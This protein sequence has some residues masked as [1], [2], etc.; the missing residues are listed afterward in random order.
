MSKAE[1]REPR[2]EFDIPRK[3]KILLRTDNQFLNRVIPKDRARE[4]ERKKIAVNF[5]TMTK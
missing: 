5:A 1:R 2:R 4:R 3:K